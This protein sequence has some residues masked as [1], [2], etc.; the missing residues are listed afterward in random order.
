MTWFKVDDRLHSHPKAAA[1][2]LAA[3]G[4]WAIAG[5][6]SSDHLTDGFMPDHVIPVLSRGQIE[7]ADEL[8]AAGLWRR[9][10]G[11]YRFHQ[12]NANGDGTRRNP[13]KKEVEEE[14][15]K[16]AEAG[17]KGG[18]ASAKTRSKTQARASPLAKAPA[19]GFV[20]PPTRPPPSTKEDGERARA[21]AGR[22]AL[23]EPDAHAPPN[24]KPDYDAIERR[25][26]T[27]DRRTQ[28]AA[29]ARKAA[30]PRRPT[31]PRTVR[32]DALAELRAATPGAP[33][34]PATEEVPDP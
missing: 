24:G 34:P 15:R 10:R 27:G 7:L 25:A 12:W 1:S 4:L 21:D 17:R 26:A 2:T 11:G 32:V 23:P 9:V 31:P 16:K 8:C 13:T 19:S 33:V 14:R 29:T 3:I 22:G 5:S 18:L 20:Q 30:P 6:W 28:L